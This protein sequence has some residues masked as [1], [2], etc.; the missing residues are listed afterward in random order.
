[1][2]QMIFV[3][4]PVT[5]LERSKAFYT[6]I[7]FTVEPNFTNEQAACMVWSDSIFVML[8][9]HDFWKTFTSKAIPNARESAQV[10]LAISRESKEAVDSIVEAA[11]A[12]GG[13]ADCNPKQ[14]FGFMYGRSFEDPDGHIWEPNWM[15][16]QA[17]LEGAPV[18]AQAEPA[19]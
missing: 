3:N 5:D 6:A 7:G 13:R 11:A 10:M 18:A 16:M 17:A 14:D 12:N 4:L 9:T 19:Q 1:M 15:D 8:L 2:N